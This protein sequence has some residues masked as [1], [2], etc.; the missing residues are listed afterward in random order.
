MSRRLFLVTTLMF[1]ALIVALVIAHNRLS[2][3]VVVDNQSDRDFDRLIVEL[4]A[5]RVVIAP[6]PR[7]RRLTRAF[8]P[9]GNTGELRY[10]LYRAGAVAARGR[11]EYGP[12]GDVF[13]RIRFRID[14]S[15]ELMVE[16]RANASGEDR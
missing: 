7:D 16:S 12:E 13:R 6:V 15:G 14:S 8:T 11:L 2:P 3:A 4:P 9:Q 1:A 10:T 5:D